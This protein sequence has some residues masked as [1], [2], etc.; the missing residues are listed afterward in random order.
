MQVKVTKKKPQK[1]K[2][3]CA[4]ECLSQAQHHMD[5]VSALR[6]HVHYT[7]AERETQAHR[8]RAILRVMSLPVFAVF[9]L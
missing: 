8:I 3:R 7:R 4:S 6:S 9:E 2:N 1:P 5:Q